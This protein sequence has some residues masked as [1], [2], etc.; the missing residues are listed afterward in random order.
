MN[1]QLL[2]LCGDVMTG[3]GIDQL[4]AQPSSPELHESWIDDARDYV[5]L[6]ERRSG[7][8]P[9]RVTP[10]YIWGDAL[11][12][13]DREKPEVRIVNLET[14]VTRSDDWSEEKG[15]HYRMHPGNVGGLSVAGVD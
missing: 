11:E 13:L 14:A 6:A 9:R 4:L 12:V 7:P 2:F 1:G 10:A 15:I 5:A 3:R 8:L